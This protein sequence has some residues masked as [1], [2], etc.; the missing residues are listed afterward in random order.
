M[1]FKVVKSTSRKFDPEFPHFMDEL[2]EVLERQKRIYLSDIYILCI[3]KAEVIPEEFHKLMVNDFVILNGREPE[4]GEVPRYQ[5]KN[6]F[7]PKETCPYPHFEQ[8][9]FKWH[10]TKD[11]LELLWTLPGKEHAGEMYNDADNVAPEWRENVRYVVDY[12]NGKLKHKADELNAADKLNNN[13]IVTAY[14]DSQMTR[15]QDHK[16]LMDLIFKDRSSKK[17]FK[18]V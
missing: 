10:R 5:F 12:Y 18:G 3:P 14:S 4:E 1:E 11:E 16:K 17:Q 6:R 15:K 8:T 9:V 2:H 7:I 13:I